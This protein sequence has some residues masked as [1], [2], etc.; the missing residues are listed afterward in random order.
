MILLEVC[1]NSANS[2][3]AAQEGGALRVELCENLHEGGTTPSHGQLLLAR[4]RLNI[5]IYVLIRPRPGDFLYTNLEFEVMKADIKHCADMGCNGIVV[6]ILNEDG[7]VDKQRCSELSQLA[8]EVGLA[9]TFHRAFDL[10]ADH[11]QALEDI[12][13]MGFDRILT[14]GGKS[15]AIEGVAM[16]RH[17][18]DK[19]GKR[20]SIMAG[21]GINEHNAADLVRFTGV[22]EI[23]ASARTIEKSKM[24]Y[25]N[26]HILMSAHQRDDYIIDETDANRVKGILKAVRVNE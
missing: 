19:A 6:G 5:D 17:L 9:T 4:K 16:I 23:H 20:I 14:S 24:K 15:T 18:V 7:S 21:S 3:L 2:A 11:Y 12:S 25:I 8:K 13:D 10:C 26:D 1:A 22:K